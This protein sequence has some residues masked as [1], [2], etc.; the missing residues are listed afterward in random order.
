M[1]ATRNAPR[2]ALRS[3]KRQIESPWLSLR[4]WPRPSADRSLLPRLVIAMMGLHPGHAIFFK[5]VVT[6]RILFRGR[7]GSVV[8]PILAANPR[9][10]AGTLRLRLR[11]R[12]RD[13]HRASNDC[14]CQRTH[15]NKR[16]LHAMSPLALSPPCG[17][18][19]LCC[20]TNQKNAR[21]VGVAEPCV[22]LPRVRAQS[23]H[24]TGQPDENLPSA[25]RRKRLVKV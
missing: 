22:Q 20:R 23:H 3:A 19:R 5:F 11:L 15:S 21:S 9:R 14:E 13:E 2:F 4:Y 12:L 6:I 7:S 25:A 16:F 17:R 24:R 10:P 1:T 8:D 18:W